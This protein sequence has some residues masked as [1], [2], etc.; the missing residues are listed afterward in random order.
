MKKILVKDRYG[1]VID[2]TPEPQAQCSHCLGWFPL[3][4]FGAR[5]KK[6]CSMCK[7]TCKK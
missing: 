1:N 3:T 5:G 4:E 2:V 7:N 6:V